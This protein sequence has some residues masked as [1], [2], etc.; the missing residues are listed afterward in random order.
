MAGDTMADDAAAVI[1]RPV[2]VTEI[3]EM[4]D[5]KKDGV[6]VDATAGTGGH[7]VEILK[8]L[9]PDGRLIALD[10][11][12]QALAAT[13]R[14]F[15][16]AGFTPIDANSG[17]ATASNS[18]AATA[19]NS[20]AATASSSGAA[21]ASSSGAARFYL[22][23]GNF[24]DIPDHAAEC[25]FSAVDGI[26]MDLGMSMM[27]LKTPERG[28]SF[29]SDAR[30]DMRMDTGSALT[31]WDIVNR[32]SEKE[33]GRILLSLGEEYRFRK[34]ARTICQRRGEKSIDT[35]RE[36]AALVESALGRSGRTHP[37][38]RTFQAL[39]IYVNGELEALDTALARIP[40]VLKQG[41][42]LCILS[43]H[44][45]ED[46]RVKHFLRQRSAE[47]VLKILTKKPLIAT[48]E[49]MKENPSARSAKLRGGMKL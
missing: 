2:M 3:M 9:G 37:A 39:R 49:E 20:G 32:V 18:G 33:L 42:R 19:S 45:L 13:R 1:H 41:G 43:Y 12:I 11:D 4:L 31:A 8:R 48:K 29:D 40:A 34:L 26:L 25:G 7:S 35:C 16:S 15:Q 10:R 24:S 36:L 38:T 47:K 6:Y 27:Q 44:S 46:R 5:I 30:L 28:F 14:S 23:H 22:V 21:T 17:A